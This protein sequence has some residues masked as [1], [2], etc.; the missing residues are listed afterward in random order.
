MF[1]KVMCLVVCGLMLAGSAFAYTDQELDKNWK[2]ISHINRAKC[3][4][5]TK[6][7]VTPY[8]QGIELSKVSY[9]GWL[10]RNLR[11][12]SKVHE[13]LDTGEVLTY[14]SD[15]IDKTEE[16]LTGLYNSGVEDRVKHGWK[17]RLFN[18]TINSLPKQIG[19]ECVMQNL[20]E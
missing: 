4:V 10:K 18:M 15:D 16:I 2:N 19:E 20:Y 12:L 8:K 5:L 1:K 13:K 14:S 3:I 7:S 6:I 9:E 17:P 11:D